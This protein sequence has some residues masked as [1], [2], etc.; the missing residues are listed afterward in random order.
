MI[1]PLQRKREELEPK[2]EK[3]DSGISGLDDQIKILS[4]GGSGDDQKVDI[5][6]QAGGGGEKLREGVSGSGSGERGTKEG[7]GGGGGGGG[8]GGV[9]IG[10]EEE[11]EEEEGKVGGED[12]SS[13]EGDK[14]EEDENVVTRIDEVCE[15][16]N[17]FIYMHACTVQ[18]MYVHV[19]IHSC[20]SLPQPSAC[21]R[22]HTYAH[23]ICH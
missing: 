18:Y 1:D 13:R 22:T 10:E 20:F 19:W 8:G 3:R 11:E 12:G 7:R 6:N 2:H 16:E 21:T 4:G 5:L 15:L 14:E 17:S 9:G 23:S